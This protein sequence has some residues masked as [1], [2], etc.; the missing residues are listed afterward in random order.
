MFLGVG[1][2]GPCIQTLH[3]V[4]GNTQ[5]ENLTQSTL[6]TSRV[7]VMGWS[8]TSMQRRCCTTGWPSILRPV[9]ALGQSHFPLRVTVHHLK[10]FL[11]FV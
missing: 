10:P 5:V 7:R 3:C 8:R 6:A 4:S 9:M 1:V 11:V 2:R